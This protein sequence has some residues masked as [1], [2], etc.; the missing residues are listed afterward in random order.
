MGR[1]S[2]KLAYVFKK[3]PLEN[4][5]DSDAVTINERLIDA[6]APSAVRFDGTRVRIGGRIRRYVGVR[7]F[8]YHNAFGWLDDVKA[9]PRPTITINVRRA[10]KEKIVSAINRTSSV[11][12]VKR[13]RAR[14]ASKAVLADAE[15]A[16]AVEMMSMLAERDKTFLTCSFTAFAEDEDDALLRQRISSVRASCA[17]RGITIDDLAEGQRSAFLSCDPMA[18]FNDPY[19]RPRFEADLQAGALAAMAPF[20]TAGIMDKEGVDLG[21]DGQGALVRV[22]MT[23]PTNARPNGHIVIAGKSGNGKSYLLKTIVCHEY[24]FGSRVIWLDW[25]Q[26]AKALCKKLYG[27]YLNCSGCGISLSP[28]MYRTVNFEFGDGEDNSDAPIEVLRSTIQFLGGFFQLAFGIDA[29][30]LPYL[31][32]GLEIAY[33][34]YGVA[35][36]TPHDQIDYTR[37]PSMD[38]VASIFDQLA[39]EEQVGYVQRIYLNLAAHARTGGEKGLYGNFWGGRTD[40]DLTSDF[41]VFDL[42]ALTSVP[43]SVRNAQMYSILSFVWGEI[44]KSRAYDVPLRLVLDEAHMLLCSTTAND[45]SKHASF[46][47]TTLLAQIC[48]RARKYNAQVAIATQ[49]LHEF[50]L[51]NDRASKDARAI[52]ENMTYAFAFGMEEW[53]LASDL[54]QIPSERARELVRYKRRRCILKV[55]SGDLVDLFVR[56]SEDLEPWF[57]NAGGR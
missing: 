24:A 39:K 34:R 26:E 13:E 17:T 42:S 27:Q 10:D 8:A 44:C 16:D 22:N 37:Y 45:G 30:D 53:Q 52:F 5:S 43:E 18:D 46:A 14:L 56:R 9:L 51:G 3:E 38:E 41:V 31:F 33:G 35:Y 54:L 6:I 11:A 15:S 29:S 23:Y 36:D 25:E 48:R 4:V 47:S 40:V 7:Q 12:S 55:G 21:E 50:D 20:D 28:L 32:K 19:I 2:D 57:G 49:S 1:L